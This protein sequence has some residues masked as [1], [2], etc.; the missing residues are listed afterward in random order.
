MEVVKDRGLPVEWTRVDLGLGLSRIRTSLEVAG[1]MEWTV[2]WN[3]LIGNTT[4]MPTTPRVRISSHEIATE[5]DH[6]RL[7]PRFTDSRNFS[8]P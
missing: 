7:T 4:M 1:M 3:D 6:K 5:R 8:P 2:R